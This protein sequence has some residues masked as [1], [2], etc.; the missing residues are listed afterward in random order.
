MMRRRA[1][2][3][4][5]AAA[6]LL[7]FSFLIQRESLP[8]GQSLEAQPWEPPWEA[9]AAADPGG[10]PAAVDEDPD[11]EVENDTALEGR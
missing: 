7:V 4:A 1:F 9:E 8:A 6:V 2:L 10:T 11:E 5:A 3:G